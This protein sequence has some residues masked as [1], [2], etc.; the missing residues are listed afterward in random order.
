MKHLSQIIGLIALIAL[1]A[2]CDPESPQNAAFTF[3]PKS[4]IDAPLD[5]S[6][7]PPNP[8]LEIIAHAADPLTIVLVEF[9]VNGNPIGTFQNPDPAQTLIMA[10]QLW[11]PPAP[12]N[13]TVWVRAQNSASVWGEYA[14]A[15]ITIGGATS[16]TR[17][18]T[19]VAPIVIATPRPGAPSPT[20]LPPLTIAFSADV[21]T[22]ILGQCANLRWQVANASQVLLDNVSVNATGAKQSCPNQ[23]TTHTLRVISLDG[24]TV[25]RA[26]TLNVVAPTRTFT[27]VPRGAPTATRTLTPAPPSCSG[28]PIIASFTASPT[29][30][31][32]GGA[33]TLSWGAVLNA[34]AVEI[35][36][37]IGGVA[38][39]GSTNVSPSATT[40]Y[41]LT[42]R[43][44]GATVIARAV[45][46]VL[47][48]PTAPLR[49]LP[50]A[51]PTRT[52][53][54]VR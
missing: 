29:T 32:Q 2:A 1:I 33:A 46:N 34:D 53:I 16:P 25:Q 30:I 9:S 23:T 4:W 15:E 41:V 26:L 48:P 22:V 38:T 44:K 31:T 24:Q 10:K 13:Y 50:T 21:T 49:Q 54:I 11:M 20:A 18:P 35:D 42:A 43:C 27:P 14:Q 28:N 45:V 8:A 51:T 3:G 12:G 7:Y 19:R 5:G 36:N 47:P 52:P 6:A 39:P 37:G 40:V 17:T